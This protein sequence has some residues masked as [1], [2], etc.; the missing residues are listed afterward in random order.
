MLNIMV[1]LPLVL[2]IKNS[3][4]FLIQD[5]QTYGYQINNA[6][7]QLL[8]IYINI[9]INQRAQPMLKMELIS[10]LLMVQVLLLDILEEILPELPDCQL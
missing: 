9:S 4:S 8:A 3:R 7:S 6:D 1:Q 2:Q 10:I 5:H